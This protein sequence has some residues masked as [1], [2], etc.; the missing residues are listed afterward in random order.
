MPSVS[1]GLPLTFPCLLSFPVCPSSFHAFCLSCSAPH[2]SMP[3]VSPVLPLT[4]PCLLSLLFCPFIFPCLLSLPV[5]PPS[6]HAFCL[7]RSALSPFHAFYLSCSAPIFPCLLSLLFCISPFHAF[8]L[9][10]SAPIF[11]CLLS[12][13]FCT[14]SFHAFCLSRS[15][16]HPPVSSGLLLTFPVLLPVLC[17]AVFFPSF[18]LN[19]L[20]NTFTIY[21]YIL[22]FRGT[23]SYY[24]HFCM[25]DTPLYHHQPPVETKGSGSSPPPLHKVPLETKGLSAI[26]TIILRARDRKI[27]CP[28]NPPR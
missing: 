22:N 24:H 10:C 2:L 19:F 3:S 15:A 12:L 7:S 27:S 5:C 9:S 20:S 1:P 23:N 14:S 13:L 26:R 6:F 11:P 4:F 17:L 18:P 21:I 16:L 8:Y 25:H 28:G